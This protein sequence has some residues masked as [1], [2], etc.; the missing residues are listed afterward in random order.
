[1]TVM[2]VGCGGTGSH[3]AQSLARLAVHC[4]DAGLPRL[5]L[6]FADGDTVERKNV[7]RQLFSAADVGKNKAQ[8][9]A[10]RFGAVFGLEILAFPA[11]LAGQHLQASGIGVLVGAVDNAQARREIGRELERSGGNWRIWID[12]GNHEHDGQVVAGTTSD[13]NRLK[14]ALSLG[15][16]CTALPAAPLLYPELLREEAAPRPQ[17]DCAAAMQNNAQSLMINQAMATVAAQY[18]YGLV[19]QRRITTFRTTIDLRT[20]TM[21]SVP[22]TA[23]NLA[24]ETGLALRALQAPKQKKARAA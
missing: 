14:G 22:I 3:I 4:R 6:A 1:V 17:A 10:G 9:L 24:R 2:L 18:L 16:I 21:A 15:G 8:V 13:P 5:Q 23:H 12:C 11:M 7:G 20:L 19:V